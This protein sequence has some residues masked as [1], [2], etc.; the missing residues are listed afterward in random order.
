VNETVM[1]IKLDPARQ[2]TWRYSG[3]IL[4]RWPDA[5]LIEARFNRSDLSFHGITFRQGDRF[6]EMY[7]ANHWYNIFEIHD[8]DDDRIKGWYCNVCRPAEFQEDQ[9]AYVDLALDL[10]IFPD[11]RQLILDEDEFEGLKLDEA[12]RVQAW[13]ALEEL[14]IIF[15]QPDQFR[16]DQMGLK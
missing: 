5:A 8:L 7:Y 16:I 14:K 1:I 13:T 10:L 12:L 4:H 3:K 15:Q 11:G 2:E 9:I 6:V